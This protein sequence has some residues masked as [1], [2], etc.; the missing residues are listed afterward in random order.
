MVSPAFF[1]LSASEERVLHTQAFLSP[2]LARKDWL[3]GSSGTGSYEDKEVV[4]VKLKRMLEGLC[5]GER[6]SLAEGITLGMS[7]R[8]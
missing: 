7:I 5:N 1:L 8:Y 3:H 2:L 6:A 4:T